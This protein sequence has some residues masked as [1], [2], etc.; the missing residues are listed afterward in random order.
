MCVVYK[1]ETRLAEDFLWLL[2]QNMYFKPKDINTICKMPSEVAVYLEFLN[3]EP[4]NGY[5]FNKFL[6]SHLAN[7]GAHII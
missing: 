6:A 5:L 4:Y 3:P 1:K 2:I 7:S